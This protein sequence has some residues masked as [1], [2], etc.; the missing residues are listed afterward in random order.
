[1]PWITKE[2]AHCH[3]SFEVYAYTGDQRP[4]KF[5]SKACKNRAQNTGKRREFCKRGHEFTPEN[6]RP[7][8]FG[9]ICQICYEMRMRVRSEAHRD[10]QSDNT[11][12]GYIEILE[13]W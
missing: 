1:M 6:S 11:V 2:C 7:T 12:F 13:D 3:Q 4:H 5:C 9:R 10:Y 8:S